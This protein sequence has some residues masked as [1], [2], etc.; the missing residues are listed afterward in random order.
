M[1]FIINGQG[2]SGKDT[3]VKFCQEFVPDRV[4]NISTVD[5]IKEIAQYLGWEG[6]KSEKDRKFLSDLKALSKEYN[7]LPYQQVKRVIF[8]LNE[9]RKRHP[10][11]IIFI[12]CREPDE[13]KRFVNEYKAK[14]ILVYNGSR[15]ITSNESDK[16]VNNYN[17]DFIIDNTGTFDD[18]KERARNFLEEI[19]P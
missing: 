6:G 7:D 10:H 2:G 8:S 5:Y 15:Q 4:I 16:N 13:I 14:T 18:L 3:F 1:I 12:H 19:L 17:Y 9:R 11:P